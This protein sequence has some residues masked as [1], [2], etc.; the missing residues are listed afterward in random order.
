MAEMSGWREIVAAV[1]IGLILGILLS[2]AAVYGMGR[3]LDQADLETSGAALTPH[4]LDSDRP[5]TSAAK[6]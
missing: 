2:W 4:W 6:A 5:D 3:Y 1:A